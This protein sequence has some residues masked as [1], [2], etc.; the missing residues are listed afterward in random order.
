[1]PTLCFWVLTGTLCSLRFWGAKSQLMGEGEPATNGVLTGRFRCHHFLA[2]LL[3]L[4]AGQSKLHLGKAGA[5]RTLCTAHNKKL[6]V[7]FRRLF[8]I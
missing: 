2:D 5:D 1:M 6:V 7:F 3:L 4:I 8:G